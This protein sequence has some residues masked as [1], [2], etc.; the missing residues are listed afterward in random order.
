MQTIDST[1]AIKPSWMGNLQ[2]MQENGPK[3]SPFIPESIQLTEA[4]SK[5]FN[6]LPTS[7]ALETTMGLAS[8]AHILGGAVMGA[9]KNEGVINDKHQVFDY[10]NMYIIDGSS[11]SA[12]PGVNPSLTITALAERAMSFI[13][14]KHTNTNF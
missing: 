9:D 14:E 7:F 1:L 8:T 12:N 5:S 4:Y 11:I 10:E 2:S 3:P 13:P 6:G